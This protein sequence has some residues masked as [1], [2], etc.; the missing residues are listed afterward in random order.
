MREARAKGGLVSDGEG[1][2][3]YRPRSSTT[4]GDEIKASM[5]DEETGFATWTENDPLPSYLDDITDYPLV[6]PPDDTMH[7]VGQKS[8][9][10]PVRYPFHPSFGSKSIVPVSQPS[11]ASETPVIVG[12]DRAIVDD[13]GEEMPPRRSRRTVKINEPQKTLDK[14]RPVQDRWF[15]EPVLGSETSMLTCALSRTAHDEMIENLLKATDKYE[16]AI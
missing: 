13:S 12:T 16:A 7:A 3:V 8:E 9:D 15:Y 11:S 14:R 5:G 2:V 4:G 1:L 10:L 6:S